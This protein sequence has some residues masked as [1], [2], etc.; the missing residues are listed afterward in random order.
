MKTT[1]VFAHQRNYVVNVM[2]DPG[3]LRDPAAIYINLL[4]LLAVF[5]GLPAWRSMPFAGISLR[6][7]RSGTRGCVFAVISN[8]IFCAL[9]DTFAAT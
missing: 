5:F 1:Y 9:T 2:N 7:S 6:T 3:F 8:P 4:Y